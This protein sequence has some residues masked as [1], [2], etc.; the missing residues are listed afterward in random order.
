MARESTEVQ[1]QHDRALRR[2]GAQANEDH[3]QGVRSLRSLSPSLFSSLNRLVGYPV[4]TV[5]LS[6]VGKHSCGRDQ[7]SK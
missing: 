5:L 2:Q 1:R 6:D 3:R 4:P 7:S